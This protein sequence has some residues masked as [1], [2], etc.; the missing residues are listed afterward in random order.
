MY[1][2]S[3]IKNGGK[4]I[5][6]APE[7]EMETSIIIDEVRALNPMASFILDAQRLTGLRYSDCTRI[8]L[9]HIRKGANQ[10]KSEF[11]ITQKKIYSSTMTWLKTADKA[12]KWS[13]QEKHQ[14]AI[15]NAQLRVYISSRLEDVFLS[16]LKMQESN[17]YFDATNPQ[18]YVFANSHHNSQ[19]RAMTKEVVNRLLKSEE[20]G[21]ILKKRGISNANLGTHSFR[22]DFGQRLLDADANVVDIKELM[23][24]SSLESTIK[25][26]STSDKKKR[27][28]IDSI[29]SRSVQP[30]IKGGND[31]ILELVDK[32][33]ETGAND[34]VIERLLAQ[35]K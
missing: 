25:Y 27:D 18:T 23:G 30:E 34:L 11:V 26:L 29:G 16:V 5:S 17:P 28:L 3:D 2:M 6:F 9:A 4:T 1:F 24:Q 35:L 32:A 7:S 12:A 13:D 8:N 33:L 20:L 14:Y 19:G 15:N 31:R 10:I 22:K 21:A